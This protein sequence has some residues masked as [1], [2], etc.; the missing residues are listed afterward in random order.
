MQIV[1]NRL[2]KTAVKTIVKTSLK[3]TLCNRSWPRYGRGKSWMAKYKVVSILPFCFE[4]FL[5]RAE[6]H[7]TVH[8]PRITEGKRRTQGRGKGT[9]RSEGRTEVA[10][11]AFYGI[12]VCEAEEEG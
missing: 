9:R 12:G 1:G 7:G 11:D 8:E 10:G 6:H 5:S 4:L 3:T 2:V